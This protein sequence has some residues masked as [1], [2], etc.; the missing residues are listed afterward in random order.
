MTLPPAVRRSGWDVIL[1]D[2]P[3]GHREDLPGRMKSIYEA[4]RLAAHGAKIFVHDCDRP[5]E[6]A[7]ADRYLGPDRRFIEVS[8]RA[9]LRGYAF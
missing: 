3:P 1:V 7:F 5:I 6:A 9:L 4:S 8:G 2:G